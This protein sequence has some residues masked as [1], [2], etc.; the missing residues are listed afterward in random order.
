MSPCL[1]PP[2]ATPAPRRRVAPSSRRPLAASS[3][4]PSALSIIELLACLII[5]SLLLTSVAMAFRSSF[6]SYK[7]AQQ[8]GQLLNA[9]RDLMYHLI[10]DIRMCD[11]AGPYDPSTT[12]NASI[13]SEFAAQ[14]VPGYPL[15]GPSTSGGSGVAG[16]QL[17][18]TH[19]DS[20]D[21]TASP[22]NPVLITYWFDAPSRTIFMS[23]KTG[24]APAKTY[25]MSTFVQSFTLYL[26]PVLI[27][28]NSQTS[29]PASIAMLRA[30]VTTS[31]ANKTAAGTRIL[32]DG[33]QDQTLIL[34]DSAMPRR[35]FGG[36]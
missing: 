31:L 33:G 26:Q 35:T 23:R 16:I 12:V 7:D 18:K 27:P 17:A 28:A 29:T 15:S 8:R 2:R 1:A 21:P 36:S 5:S 30:V 14:I 6:N 24:S 3:R 10:S 32:A 22:S 34:T 9:G 20:L 13:Q 11:S 4:R 25:T 19:A